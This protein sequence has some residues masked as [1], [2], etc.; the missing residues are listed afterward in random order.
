MRRIPI[1]K[2][3]FVTPSS[4]KEIQTSDGVLHSNKIYDFYNGKEFENYLTDEKE[5]PADL[6]RLEMS[7]SPYSNFENYMSEHSTKEDTDQVN[8][9][10]FTN[11]EREKRNKANE[12]LIFTGIISLDEETSKYIGF[13]SN[14]NTKKICDKFFNEMMKHHKFNKADWRYFAAEHTN[15]ENTHLHVMIYQPSTIAANK[16]VDWTKKENCITSKWVCSN[17]IKYT[18]QMT[19]ERENSP[20]IDELF[21]INHQMKQEFKQVINSDTYA[22]D[23]RNLANE[24]REY[25]DGTGRLQY[26]NLLKIANFDQKKFDEKNKAVYE[27]IENIKQSPFYKERKAEEF[28][29]T[30]EFTK[31]SEK[32]EMLLGKIDIL[33]DSIKK[34]N[35][36]ISPTKAKYFIQRIDDLADFAV[37]DNKLLSQ[38]KKFAD[39]ILSKAYNTNTDNSEINL[40]RSEILADKKAEFKAN[41]GNEILNSIKKMDIH[42]WY[43]LSRAGY[44]RNNCRKYVY[45][46]KSIFEEFLKKVKT[47]SYFARK[48]LYYNHINE[49]TMNQ[50]ASE[51]K[52]NKWLDQLPD[53]IKQ[54]ILEQLDREAELKRLEQAAK[55]S[56]G[57]Q[58]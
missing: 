42:R 10:T 29:N 51:F 52:F 30:K 15:T 4:V 20:L 32:R 28:A 34:P 23:L 53:S 2:I 55:N 9:R 6:D 43:C 31:F 1:V 21:N 40:I 38:Q 56:L 39:Q 57:W 3:N 19:Y 41:L 24:L 5:H 45:K 11:D 33:K 58:K 54:E 46:E 27:K 7:K 13:G 22:K 49:K 50:I 47:K 12:S 44:R 18:H 14:D 35:L 26:N 37:R 17:T 36:F 8:I 48:N 25:N 16:V